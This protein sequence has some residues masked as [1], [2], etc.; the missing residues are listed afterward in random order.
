MA[1]EQLKREILKVVC[2]RFHNLREGTARKDLVVKFR[3]LEVL[4]DLQQR[5]FIRTLNT[6]GTNERYFPTLGSFVL[7]ADE[8]YLAVVRRGALTTL[9]VLK[10]LFEVQPNNTNFTFD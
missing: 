4:S 2:D 8:G 6:N 5:G 3:N 7:G 1:D 9:H 10:N